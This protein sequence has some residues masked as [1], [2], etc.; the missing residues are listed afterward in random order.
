VGFCFS[1]V[2]ICGGAALYRVNISLTIGRESAA[3]ALPQ[4]VSQAFHH[5]VVGVMQAVAL[6]GQ[7][8]NRLANAAWLVDGA[9]FADGDMHGQMQK[10]VGLTA[11]AFVLLG[12][13][14]INVR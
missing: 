8:L 11:V 13:R 7:Q 2:S 4:H 5:L 10:R 3:L 1:R 14:R 12:Q 6:S 9:L